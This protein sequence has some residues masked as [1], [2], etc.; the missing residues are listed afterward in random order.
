MLYLGLKLHK[1]NGGAK[2]KLL[3]IIVLL[4]LLAFGIWSTKNLALD[5]ATGP[6]EIELHDVEVSKR[7]GTAGLA[8]LHYYLEGNDAEGNPYRMDISEEDYTNLGA[9]EQLTVSYYENTKRL[10]ALGGKG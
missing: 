4:V 10:Y 1:G 2:Q 8:S 9:T 6:Q 5:L 7:Q 3:G